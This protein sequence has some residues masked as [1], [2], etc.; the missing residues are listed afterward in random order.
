MPSIFCIRCHISGG[1]S[2]GALGEGGGSGPLP[3]GQKKEMTEVNKATGQ[4]N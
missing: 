4:L 3:L 2:G 1:S